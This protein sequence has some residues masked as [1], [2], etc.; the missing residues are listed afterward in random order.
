MTLITSAV[1]I[2]RG[3][4]LGNANANTV[5]SVDRVN[6]IVVVTEE[7]LE[8]V[9]IPTNVNAQSKIRKNNPSPI[10]SILGPSSR[11]IRP[12]FC[13]GEDMFLFIFRKWYLQIQLF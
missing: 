6:I 10:P 13:E 1:G 8:K 2:S 5:I 9:K 7:Y 4:Y 11:F 12:S 3:G